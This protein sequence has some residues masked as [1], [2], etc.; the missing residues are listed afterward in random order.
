[1]LLN[2]LFQIE[3][4]LS[5]DVENRD[6]IVI[7]FCTMLAC[8]DLLSD[9]SGTLSATGAFKDCSGSEEASDYLVASLYVAGTLQRCNF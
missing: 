8:A 2:I 4:T 3:R 6:S 5:H 1:M 9:F 7:D